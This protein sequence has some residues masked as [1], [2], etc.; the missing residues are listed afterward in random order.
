[1]VNW[2]KRRDGNRAVSA[3]MWGHKVSV[4]TSVFYA[5]RTAARA[6]LYL[7][8]L[9][10]GARPPLKTSVSS[11]GAR[12]VKWLKRRDGNRAVSACIWVI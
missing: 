5:K 6:T 3:C 10:R 7:A 12:L 1:M 9:A 4:I 2:L 11:P 8:E